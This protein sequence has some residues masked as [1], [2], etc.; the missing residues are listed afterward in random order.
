MCLPL[1][2]FIVRVSAS[3]NLYINTQ[4]FDLIDQVGAKD[5]IK[6]YVYITSFCLIFVIFNVLFFYP[7]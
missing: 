3:Q 4:I 7:L 5:S 1:N 6:L 2:Q